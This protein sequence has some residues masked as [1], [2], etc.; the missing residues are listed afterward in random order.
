MMGPMVAAVTIGAFVVPDAA[1]AKEASATPNNTKVA[2]VVDLKQV[3]SSIL[4]VIE[5]DMEQRG[6]GTSLYGTMIRL[7]W[8][9]AGTYSAADASGGCNGARMRFEPECSWGANAGLALARQ[10]LEPVKAQFPNLSYADLYAYAGV[11]AVEEAGGP[12]VKF[13]PGRVDVESGESSPPD[14]RLPDADKGS[15]QQTIQHLRDIFYRMSFT[16]AE[17]VALSGAH[18]MGRCHT[19][20]SGMCYCVCF[21]FVSHTCFCGASC[22][23]GQLRVCV[24]VIM[25]GCGR[26]CF[27]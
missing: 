25:L 20:R 7:A 5:T 12:V 10:A 26:F 1:Y 16:D 13:R 9:C 18:A 15:R 24:E 4:D 27:H 11:V 8:H 21:I 17:I 23:V 3:R 6:D 14:G 2:A 19:D 22:L